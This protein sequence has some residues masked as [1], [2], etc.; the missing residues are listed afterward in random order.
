MY[1]WFQVIH[2]NCEVG[3]VV[4]ETWSET[5]TGKGHPA[6]VAGPVVGVIMPRRSMGPAN[7]HQLISQRNISIFKLK[8]HTDYRN[9]SICYSHYAEIP[10][11]TNRTVAPGIFYLTRQRELFSLTYISS[12]LTCDV[13][14]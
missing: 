13:I 9:F 5:R 11:G 10:E 4:T 12:I 1:L 14:F 8:A 3:G 6:A 2:E 7:T